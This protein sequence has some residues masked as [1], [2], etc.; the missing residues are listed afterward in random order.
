MCL[1]QQPTAKNSLLVLLVGAVIRWY[2]WVYEPIPTKQQFF[3]GKSLYKKKHL[4]LDTFF[5]M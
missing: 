1:Y 5:Y 4:I 2:Y 3:V